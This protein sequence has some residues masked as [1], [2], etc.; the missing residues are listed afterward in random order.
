MC[1]KI[2]QFRPNK[3]DFRFF[4]NL[5]SLGFFFF[6]SQHWTTDVGRHKENIILIVLLFI[7]SKHM[8]AKGKSC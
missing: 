8:K 7:T 2:G 4:L 6:C 1:F 5:S 3:D